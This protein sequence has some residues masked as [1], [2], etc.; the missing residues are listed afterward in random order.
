MDHYNRHELGWNFRMGFIGFINDVGYGVI[1]AFLS[2]LSSNFDRNLQFAQFM[3]AVQAMP[4]LARMWNA[5]YLIQTPHDLRLFYVSLSQILAYC[6][7]FAAIAY[8]DEIIGIPC[9]SL[10]AMVFQCSRTIGES[11]IIGYIKA[12]P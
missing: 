7:L 10:A 8:P 2:Q 9:A 3:V 12:I 6:L 5:N 4:I 11:T 1:V